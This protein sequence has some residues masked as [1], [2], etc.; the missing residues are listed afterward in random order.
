MSIKLN[1]SGGGSAT[2][3]EPTTASALTHT[4]PAV[5]GTLVSTGDTG[6][7][8]TTMLAASSVTTAKIAD[9]NITTAK[10]ADANITPAKLSQPLP[11]MT[12][13]ASTSGTAINFTGI[14]SW[15][16]R[17]TVLFSSVSLSGTSTVLLQVGSGSY[18][19][20]GYLGGTQ[21]GVTL[22][23]VTT[24]FMVSSFAVA[25]DLRHGAI[26]LLNV[27]GNTWVATGTITANNGAS[28]IV[29]GTIALG[30]VLDRL[31]VTSSNGT[32]TFDSGSI[33]VLYEG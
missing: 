18:T 17:I 5:N 14:P 16:N 22:T 15:V 28:A 23:S 30:G 31:R 21:T 8:S 33:N 1:S 24:G 11:L 32:D 7:V 29:S 26:T 12:S 9:A 25:T 10:I 4:L 3:Q 6:T 20:T 13:Q 27:T 2:I 19:T